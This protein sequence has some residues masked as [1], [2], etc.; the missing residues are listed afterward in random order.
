MR[1]KARKP[2][3]TANQHDAYGKDLLRVGVW[4]DVAK[5]DTGEAAEGEVKCS[6]IL[7][8]DGGPRVWV[9]VIV[10]LADGYTQV[11]E[12][13][14]LMLQVRLLHIPNGIPYAGQP[15]GNQCEN[16]H[17]QHQYSCSILRVAVQFPGYSD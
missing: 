2:R 4:R 10:P 3:L 7:V 13:A 15:M 5:P 11:I 9:S 17:Q 6:D 1:K 16:A 8:L 12:P 14:D